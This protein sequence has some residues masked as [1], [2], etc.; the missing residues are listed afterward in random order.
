MALSIGCDPA[1]A[2]SKLIMHVYMEN[3]RDVA[4]D[5]LLH[6]AVAEVL[7]FACVLAGETVNLF[8]SGTNSCIDPTSAGW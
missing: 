6:G 1:R 5:K 4:L 7:D 8:A 2:L 3:T